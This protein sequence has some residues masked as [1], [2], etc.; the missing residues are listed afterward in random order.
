MQLAVT[1]AWL[2]CGWHTRGWVRRGQQTSDG[3]L[4][5]P[6]QA[7]GSEGRAGAKP[8]RVLPAERTA[9]LAPRP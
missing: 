2:G 3:P 5:T 7:R 9:Q 8:E 1:R 4:P 6:A